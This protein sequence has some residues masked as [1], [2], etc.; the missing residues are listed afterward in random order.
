[1]LN[2]LTLYCWTHNASQMVAVT[3][4]ATAQQKKK[5]M[6]IGRFV[7]IIAIWWSRITS[8][9]VFSFSYLQ[10]WKKTLLIVSHDQSFLDDVCTDIIHLDN[11]KLYYYRG[12]YREFRFKC[13]HKF[14]LLKEV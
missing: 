2:F 11:Q 6:I 7:I 8:P 1:M 9:L 14:K 3:L 5:T 13:R 4:V 10:S 12:N